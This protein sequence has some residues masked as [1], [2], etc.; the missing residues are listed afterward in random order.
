MNAPAVSP[1]LPK[2]HIVGRADGGRPRARKESG[3]GMMASKGEKVA[4]ENPRRTLVREQL[5]DKAADV[6]LRQ[7]F[8]ATRILD[9]ADGLS[10]SR[11]ALYHYFSSKDEILAALIAEHSGRR[12]REV[13][14]YEADADLPPI[15]KFRTMLRTTV[16]ERLTGGS[17][18]RA[19]DQISFEMPAELRR[20]FD[21][22]RRKILDAYTHVIDE[23]I[24][25]GEFR[26]VDPQ[27]AAFAVLGIGNWTSWW[28][29]PGGRMSPD[30]L[31]AMLVDIAEASLR[32]P[33]S[34]NSAAS[35]KRGIVQEIRTRLDLLEYL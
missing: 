7:G 16:M 20:D 32:A 3:T 35:D 28:Y 6:F 1:S 25:T 24:K 29:S 17:R 34:A 23:A 31:T 5:L 10:L 11:S 27:V 33:P 18:M 30:D 22:S 13:E 2:C 21:V 14:G 9:I 26:V 15:D 19:L 8:A 4:G 12:A